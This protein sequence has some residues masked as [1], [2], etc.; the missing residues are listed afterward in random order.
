M[1]KV[2]CL[3]SA[4]G[5]I[6]AAT[7]SVSA[8]THVTRTYNKGSYKYTC[9]MPGKAETCGNWNVFTPLKTK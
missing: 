1:R 6:A 2:L 9:T 8:A 5:L 4:L 3:L 7:G